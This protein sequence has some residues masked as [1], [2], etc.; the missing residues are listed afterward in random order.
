MLIWCLKQL[1]D[2][3]IIKFQSVE[4][5]FQKKFLNLHAMIFDSFRSGGCVDEVRDNRT[6]Y[7]GYKIFISVSIRH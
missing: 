5:S 4:V 2:F 6:N 3:I 7:Q 1:N